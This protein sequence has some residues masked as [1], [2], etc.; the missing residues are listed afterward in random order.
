MGG[1]A[2]V[3]SSGRLIILTDA[4]R[5]QSPRLVLEMDS[6]GERWCILARLDRGQD[7]SKTRAALLLRCQPACLVRIE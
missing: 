6:G 1:L 2:C 5:D 4:R 7:E 3:E